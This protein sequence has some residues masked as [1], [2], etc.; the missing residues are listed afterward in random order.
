MESTMKLRVAEN[1]SIRWKIHLIGASGKNIENR[2]IYITDETIGK[3]YRAEDIK[4]PP[5]E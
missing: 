2:E 4:F 3:F 1:R 5:G